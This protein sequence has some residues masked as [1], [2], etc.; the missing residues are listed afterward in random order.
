MTEKLAPK[1]TIE[2]MRHLVQAGDINLTEIRTKVRQV[3]NRDTD[4]S[5]DDLLEAIAAQ[6]D[7]DDEELATHVLSIEDRNKLSAA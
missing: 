5:D 4:L 1:E 2:E 7:D 6:S 3:L